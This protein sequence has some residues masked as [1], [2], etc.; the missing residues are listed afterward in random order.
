MGKRFRSR[1]VQI[2]VSEIID[3]IDDEL[4]REEYEDRFGAAPTNGNLVEEIERCLLNHDPH[5]ALALI[6]NAR[7]AR[8]IPETTRASQYAQLR[9]NLQ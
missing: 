8:L 9:S 3:E 5:A 2:D 6:E 7:T 4:L 1:Y